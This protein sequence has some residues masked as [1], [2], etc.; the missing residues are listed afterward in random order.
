MVSLM[1]RLLRNWVRA[2]SVFPCP[3]SAL[4]LPAQPE[5][6][7]SEETSAVGSGDAC[8]PFLP[9]VRSDDVHRCTAE[10]SRRPRADRC[11]TPSHPTVTKRP[12]RDRSHMRRPACVRGEEYQITRLEVRGDTLCPA[13]NSPYE[14]RGVRKMRRVESVDGPEQSTPLRV[15]AAPGIGG[16]DELLRLAGDLLNEKIPRLRWRGR[17]AMLH[18]GSR[19]RVGTGGQRPWSDRFL[20]VPR[21]EDR[22]YRRTWPTRCNPERSKRWPSGGRR[23]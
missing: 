17:P 19:R 2:S 22:E 8:G 9:R 1:L 3:K 23:R 18:L 12:S 20:G 15:V 13:V 21:E 4:E 16:P 6:R 11:H 14:S 10:P 7:E 5:A